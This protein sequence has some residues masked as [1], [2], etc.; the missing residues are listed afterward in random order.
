M[1]VRDTI[2]SFSLSCFPNFQCF[3]LFICAV[4]IRQRGR[5]RISINWSPEKTP[6]TS[7]PRT[8]TKSTTTMTLRSS[9]RK[10]LHLADGTIASISSASSSTSTS[11]SG[12]NIHSIASPRKTTRF[13]SSLNANYYTPQTKRSRII[14]TPLAQ[15]NVTTPLTR[16]LKGLS[17][18]QL[19]NVIQELVNNEP[20]FESKIRK[21]LPM[22]DIKPMEEQLIQLKKNIFKFKSLPM[23]RLVKNTD[24]VAHSR[25]S[26]HLAALKKTIIDQSRQ[27][28]DSENWDALMDY[29]LM[30]WPYIRAIPIW[31]NTSHN[32]TRRSCFKILSWHCLCALKSA[33]QLL[34]EKRLNEFYSHIESMQSDC[35]D[36]GSCATHLINALDAINETEYTD[37]PKT[38]ST[39]A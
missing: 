13:Q 28:N 33:K 21:Q 9:P 31:E 34:G 4:V 38:S 8:P 16:V 27:L 39:I 32:A 6:T 18:A 22:P 26:T 24:S 35:D 11:T 7:N 1:K 30:A 2:Y 37:L 20:Q 17:H 3:L 15:R 19:I 12:S 5:R 14:E 29:C 23:S 10:R 36:I 25:A